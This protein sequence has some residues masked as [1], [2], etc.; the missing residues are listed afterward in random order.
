MQFRIL[1]PDCV[2]RAPVK[3]R[4]HASEVEVMGA[5]QRFICDILRRHKAGV[6]LTPVTGQHTDVWLAPV[7]GQ[8]TGVWLTPVI[9]QHTGGCPATIGSGFV[10]NSLCKH[11]FVY[12][13]SFIFRHTKSTLEDVTKHDQVVR[14]Q[15][16]LINC[17]RQVLEY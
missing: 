14:I 11:F 1:Q 12:I 10:L 15:Q 9:G 2:S 6:W 4:S 7:T 16:T 3:K 5:V 13:L 17:L 8:H